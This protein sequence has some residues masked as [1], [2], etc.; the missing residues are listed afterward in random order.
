MLLDK[1]LILDIMYLSKNQCRV[2]R[3]YS[4]KIQLVELILAT[5]DN[6][7]QMHLT[8]VN[9]Q[10]I[11]RNSFCVKLKW[12]KLGSNHQFHMGGITWKDF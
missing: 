6:I 4:K 11:F 5:K 2:S 9:Q 7:S 3:A 12:I 8:K 10:S 1:W